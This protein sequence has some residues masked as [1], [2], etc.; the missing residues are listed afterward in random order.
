MSRRQG[1]HEVS[2]GDVVSTWE[3]VEGVGVSVQWESVGG[4]RRGVVMPQWGP[5]S[6][7]TPWGS[8]QPGTE[9]KPEP[10]V[11]WACPRRA[12]RSPPHGGT[13]LVGVS[14][15]ELRPSRSLRLSSQRP[16]CLKL[17]SPNAAAEAREPEHPSLLDATLC[18]DPRRACYS[19]EPN[20]KVSVPDCEKKNSQRSTSCASQ[21]QGDALGLDSEAPISPSFSER[22]HAIV[23]KNS[24]ELKV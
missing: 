4:F 2:G 9:R 14:V 5:H 10:R 23:L 16:V 12:P 15:G 8:S 1:R 17:G 11:G 19:P 22:K 13:G 21:P 24:L 20:A 7:V 3:T 6:P 18:S